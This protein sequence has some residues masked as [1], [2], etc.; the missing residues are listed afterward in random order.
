MAL[1]RIRYTLQ[2]LACNNH[3]YIRLTRGSCFGSHQYT[4]WI[5]H[6]LVQRGAL[7]SSPIAKRAHRDYETRQVGKTVA[8]CSTLFKTVFSTNQ[9]GWFEHMSLYQQQSTEAEWDELFQ[10]SFTVHLYASG[11]GAKTKIRQR[12]CVQFPTCLLFKMFHMLFF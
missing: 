1:N 2:I 9:I 11:E 12:R 8:P 6:I 10:D 5:F 4:W 7:A 3:I